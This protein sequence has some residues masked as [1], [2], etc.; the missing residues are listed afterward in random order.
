[1]IRFW[2]F[3][4]AA[5]PLSVDCSRMAA[6]SRRFSSARSSRAA[7][8]CSRKLA[9]WFWANILLCSRLK[10]FCWW[11]IVVDE[12]VCFRR[13]CGRSGMYLS[14]QSLPRAERYPRALIQS[15]AGYFLHRIS[16]KMQKK[17]SLF[18]SNWWYSV[19]VSAYCQITTEIGQSAE[20][21]FVGNF[22]AKT[23]VWVRA[24]WARH[25]T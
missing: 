19:T 11:C 4:R 6:C 13:D 16:S 23:V 21:I 7:F 20:I 14:F 22:L 18:C 8:V 1:M 25:R 2:Y 15:L 24:A 5:Y 3:L 9:F 17:I 12:S 10:V